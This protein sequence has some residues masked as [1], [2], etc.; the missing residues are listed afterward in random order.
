[1]IKKLFISGILGCT[2]FG[3][4][5]CR[6]DYSDMKLPN[7]H[8]HPK[9]EEVGNIHK[10][11]APLYWSVYERAYALDGQVWE[12]RTIPLSEWEANFDWV[13]KELKPYGY[14]M[15]CTDGFLPITC[16]DGQPYMTRLGNVPIKD[17]IAAAKN[18]VCASV[19]TTA[20]WKHGAIPPPLSPAR[21]ILWVHCCTTRK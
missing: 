1:M 13:A 15:I 11:K 5:A 19:S 9:L 14:D 17:I 3:V 21:I 12:D 16:E 6:E 2:L 20:L 8:E 7:Q 10:F 4:C 18:A